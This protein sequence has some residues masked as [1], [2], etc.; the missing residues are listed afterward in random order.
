MPKAKQERPEVDRAPSINTEERS[1]PDV[2]PY[3]LRRWEMY[4]AVAIGHRLTL[5]GE[6]ALIKVYDNLNLRCAFNHLITM[7][8]KDLLRGIECPECIEAERAAFRLR[9]L[10]DAK[11]L[12]EARGG[13][14]L[15]D[16]YSTARSQLEWRCHKD[17]Q[18]LATLDNV[19]SKRSW[20]PTCARSKPRPGRRKGAKPLMPPESPD[21]K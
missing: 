17:H 7:K 5:K 20:C 6:P 19:R 4:R 18:W 1:E 14:C 10:E 15:S 21:A 11:E 9:Q 16:A 8:A 3:F 12:A 13:A 2:S